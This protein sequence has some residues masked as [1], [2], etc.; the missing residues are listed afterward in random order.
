MKTIKLI[1][2]RYTRWLWSILAPLGIWGVFVVA[3]ID[4]SFLG[5]PMDAIV[6]S[7]V[8]QDHSRFLLYAFLASGGS[9]LG[10]SVLYLV[11]YLGGETLLR[12]RMSQ[13]RFEKIHRSFDQHEFW[14]LMLP[15]MLP[16]PTPFKLFVLAAAVFE[17]NFGHFLLAIFAGRFV[18]FLILSLLTVKYGKGVVEL[19]AHLF[20]THLHW[21]LGI[22][23]GAILCWLLLRQMRR[24][25][26]N[27]R[28][29]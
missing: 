22:I 5:L 16:P 18:R 25:N 6:A 2:T 23:G 9:A 27:S 24:R 19:A 1:L 29:N 12:K 8:Y 10:S 15:A 4:S 13:Q 14:A 3:A 20:R 28:S 21:T 11:G 17:M 7:Y 26:R